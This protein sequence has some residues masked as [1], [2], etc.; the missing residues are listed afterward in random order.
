MCCSSFFSGICPFLLFVVWEGV[1]S[2]QTLERVQLSV[3]DHLGGTGGRGKVECLSAAV[4]VRLGEA[5][6]GLYQPDH[7]QQGGG[8]RVH[9]ACVVE[10]LQGM[11][12]S[13]RRA[14]EGSG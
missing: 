7:L 8:R 14:A 13:N 1:S 2:V 6:V 4:C 9:G 5:D 3:D 10:K 11:W 12:C